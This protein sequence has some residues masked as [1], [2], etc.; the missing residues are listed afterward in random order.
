MRAPPAP[1]PASTSQKVA[2]APPQATG[3]NPVDWY[4]VQRE[5]SLFGLLSHDQALEL[6]SSAQVRTCAGGTVVRRSERPD[7]LYVVAEGSVA[8][9]ARTDHSQRRGTVK[10]G[11]ALELR[12]LLLKKPEWEYDW[13]AETP[14][15]LLEIDAARLVTSFQQD[16]YLETYLKAVVLHPELRR[17][18]NDLRLFGAEFDEIKVTLWALSP[19]NLEVLRDPATVR[20]AIVVVQA[21]ELA[22]K[23]KVDGREREVGR[24]GP[25]DYFYC[26]GTEELTLQ[27]GDES[28]AWVLRRRA[29][30][31]SLGP[32]KAEHILRI[33]QPLEARVESV[34]NAWAP[35]E[36]VRRAAA[37]EDDGLTVKDFGRDA[38]LP[39]RLFR[40]K[41]VIERQ[42]DEMDCGAAC[43]ATL[44]RYYGRRISL[45]TYRSLVHVTRE[46]ASLL[47]V[48]R[49]A[50]ATGFQS[51]GIYSGYGGLQRMLTP[52]IALTQYHFVVVYRVTDAGVLVGDPGKGMVELSKEA[53]IKQFS[54]NALLLKP[55]E[56]FY[57]YPQSAPTFAKYVKLIR[58]QRGQLAEVLAASMLV[59]VLGLATPVFMQVVF[60]HVLV[61]AKT[62]VLHLAAGAIIL[63][64][65][66]SGSVEWVRNYLLTHQTSRLD[67]KF[68]AL[69]LRHT[70]SLPLSF[71]AVRRVGDI[72]TRLG[73][74]ERVRDFFT[75]KSINIVIRAISAV[76]YCVV[77]GLYSLKLLALL[78]A[79]LPILLG[80]MGVLI[81]RVLRNLRET[82]RAMAKNQSITFEQI[83]TLETLKSIDGLVAARWRWEVSQ[84]ET[85]DLRRK[86]ER[87]N[88]MTAG[89]SEALRGLVTIA[90]L[91]LAVYLYLEGELTVGQVV[92]VNALAGSV[93]RPVLE[94]VVEWDS[95]NQVGFSLARLDDVITSAVEPEPQ[96][97]AYESYRIRGEIEFRD[98]SF[99]YG[100]ELSPLV[101]SG[102]SVTISPGETVAFVGPSG[103]GKSTLAYMANRLY[104]PTKGQVL[105]DGV[106][107]ESI[108]TATLRR[109]IAMVLQDNHLFS[110]TVLENIT[111]GDP[112]PSMEKAMQAAIAADAHDF[113]AKMPSG[114][115][116]HLG[117]GGGQLSGGQKQRLNIARALYR[118]PTVLIMDEATAS[119]DMVSES[120]IVNNLK[121]GSRRR[122]LILIAHRLNTIMHANKIVVLVRGKVAEAGT[123]RELLERRGYYYDLYQQQR[124][125]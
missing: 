60:D 70:L 55:T 46:G 106:P 91:L 31:D 77:I 1:A 82:Y 24:F 23:A 6:L 5:Q 108:P 101:L 11:R 110:G 8:L 63:L 32:A 79:A 41:P 104:A 61:G 93:I 26:D 2:R 122:T 51:I 30:V 116:T 95:I 123:H 94:L 74:I 90:M 72:T 15:V 47:S 53:F 112:R 42:H 18:K 25:G 87:L 54:G 120:T 115:S 96:D 37:D 44:A 78:G 114:Y 88:A 103:S 119:L 102:V 21:G 3:F 98:V 9:V 36:P 45:P 56:A 75:G 57:K 121:S 14:V 86:L 84:G 67:A 20:R 111:M 50:D 17:F 64:H 48:K 33:V 16:P 7:K 62:G 40:R 89:T 109:Q 113:I 80:T 12:S 118:D 27:W 34:K 99:Q 92:A 100:S 125:A 65:L 43:M 73:E 38:K 105:I 58:D 10:E 22:V 68:S 71:F 76:T 35:E 28:K 49:A 69:F 39:R 29:W 66:F 107:A 97:Q 13:V 52:F 124:G 85:L 4:L 59:T 83:N 81:P 117:E 19:A